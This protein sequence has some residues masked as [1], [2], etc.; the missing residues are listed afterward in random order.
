[1][2]DIAAGLNAYTAILDALITAEFA[3]YSRSALGERLKFVGIAF[4]DFNTVEDF[5]R[6]P[7]LRRIAV[8]TPGGPVRLPAAPAVFEEH[9]P[10]GRVPALGAHTAAIRSEFAK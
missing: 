8:D 7:H 6:H 2:T 1:M 5:S 9:R 3:G 10:S 4:G